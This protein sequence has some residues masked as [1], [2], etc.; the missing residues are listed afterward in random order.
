LSPRACPPDTAPADNCGQRPCEADSTS[1]GLSPADQRHLEEFERKLQLVRDRVAAVALGYATGFFVD[2]PGGVSKS[3]TVLQTL[4]GLQTNYRVSNS[5]MTGRGLYDTLAAYPDSVHVL[6][7]V[8]SM[9]ADKTAVGVLR[10]ALWGQRRDGDRGPQ[11][12]WVTW[13]AYGTRLEILFTGGII[14]VSNRPLL[15]LA[16]MQALK[17]RIPCMHLQPGDNEL[18]AMMRQMS[19]RGFEHEGRKLEPQE[20]LEVCEYVVCE[21]LALH[22]PPDLRLLVNAFC[23]CIQWQEGDAGVHWHDLVAARVRER[24]TWFRDEVVLGPRAAR[25][26]QEL[27]VAREIMSVVC[28]RV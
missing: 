13:T 17:T 25:K 4:Q 3:Y 27:E 11:E 16:E 26:K 1:T 21:S 9:M 8:E 15:D 19:L 7:D 23:D 14:V 22:R 5:R 24:P 18:R 6:E 28:R 10:S 12:R 20:C 2:G